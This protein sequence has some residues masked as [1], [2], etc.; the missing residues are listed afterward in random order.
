MCF[1]DKGRIYV[2]DQG[3]RLFRITPPAPGS[4]AE[5]TVE[6]V[7]DKWGFSQGMSFIKGALYVMQQGDHSEKNFRLKSI[8]RVKDKDGDD[9]LDTAETLFQFP[10]VTGDAANWYE[11]NVHVIV[12][13]LDG[14]SIYVVSGDRNGLPSR[15][16]RTPKHWNRDR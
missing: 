14:K 1:D 2:S 5:C 7:S 11:H 3:P 4:S 13:G 12:P 9:K 16:G 8:L 6:L 10:R 15:K